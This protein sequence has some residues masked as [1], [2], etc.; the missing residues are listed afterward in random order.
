[1]AHFEMNIP[2][3]PNLDDVIRIRQWNKLQFHDP[4]VILKRL[5][6]LE[7]LVAESDLPREVKS[8]R[9]GD[10]KRDREGRNAALFCL[11]MSRAFGTDV[12]FAREEA[13]DHDFVAR[14]KRGEDDVFTPVQLKE[15]VPEPLNPLATL[16]ETLLSVTRYAALGHTAVAVLI[17]RQT[18]LVLPEIR[19][20]DVDCGG[21]WLFGAAT[22]DQRKWYLYGD[23]LDDPRLYDYEYPH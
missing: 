2:G 18:S 13:A 7:F 6:E 10:F 9:R 14:W 11:G 23:L 16:T 17:N 5:R 4:V 3:R 21:I 15:L 22:P 8:L 12:L 20:P 1:M 19:A